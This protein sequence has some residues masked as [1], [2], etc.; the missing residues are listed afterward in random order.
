LMGG[1]P[2]LANKV[3]LK[4]LFNGLADV[5]HQGD[6]AYNHINKHK[7]SNE[8]ILTRGLES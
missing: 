4:V 5:N 2:K 3:F 7:S 6:I 1:V 8:L